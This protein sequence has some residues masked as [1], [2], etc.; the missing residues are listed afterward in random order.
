MAQAWGAGAPLNPTTSARAQARRWANPQQAQPAQGSAR[1]AAPR[2]A[3]PHAARCAPVSSA[4]A[5]RAE[6]SPRP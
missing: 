3:P 5:A 4:A 1:S 6:G 2:A